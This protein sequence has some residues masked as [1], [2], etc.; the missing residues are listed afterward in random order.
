MD[1][2]NKK[3]FYSVEEV[4]K[5]IQNGKLLIIVDD[6]SSD[7]EGVFFQAAQK[8]QQESVNF[9]NNHGKSFIYLACEQGRFDL[10]VPANAISIDAYAK[11]GS[12]AS[13]A[14]KVLTI[15]SFVSPDSKS[16]AFRAPGHIFPVKSQEGGVLVRAGH[17]EASV[18]L[19]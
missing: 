14:D 2:L 16:S 15:K 17:T 5:D 3:T 19:A 9:F 11:K 12:G 6:R 8:A 10:L 7:N 1:S 4:I 18:D 13:A